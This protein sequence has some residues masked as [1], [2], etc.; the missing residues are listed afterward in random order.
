M[1]LIRVRQRRKR[2]WID[3]RKGKSPTTL[4]V[5]L[6]IVIGIIWYLGRLF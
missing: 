5:L 2:E 1:S 4:A 3:A 6:A